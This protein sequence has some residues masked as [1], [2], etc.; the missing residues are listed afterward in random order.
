MTI[1]RVT[2]FPFWVP[3]QEC[4]NHTPSIMIGNLELMSGLVMIGYD[5]GWQKLKN[6]K[7]CFPHF[8]DKF[9]AS[10]VLADFTSKYA[11]TQYANGN[12][13]KRERGPKLFLP[14]DFYKLIAG[15]DRWTSNLCCAPHS[16]PPSSKDAKMSRR[17]YRLVH[18]RTPKFFG[19]P[20]LE[21]YSSVRNSEHRFGASCI[22]WRRDILK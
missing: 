16:I 6:E 10:S 22:G 13:Q 5:V 2:T 1:P 7:R 12:D 11:R 8:G 3:I 20:F 14:S 21:M 17:T 4:T 9:L 19:R 15:T 18:P